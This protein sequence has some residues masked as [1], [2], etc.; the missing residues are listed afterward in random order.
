MYLIVYKRTINHEGDE[1]S[2]NWPGHGYPAYTE[3]VD[4]VMEIMTEAEFVNQCKLFAERDVHFR[5]YE[6]TKL[7]VTFSKTIDVQWKRL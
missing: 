1:T 2:R 3:E 4:V 7:N 6:V 5:A